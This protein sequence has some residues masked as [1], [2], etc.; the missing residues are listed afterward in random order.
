[1]IPAGDPR[2]SQDGSEK[3]AVYC[4]WHPA[5]RLGADLTQPA[6][7]TGMLL[8]TP[9]PGAPMPRGLHR[10][11]ARVAQAGPF[12]TA[13]TPGDGPLSRHFPP[14][15]WEMTPPGRLR[16]RQPSHRE[17]RARGHGPPERRPA[18]RRRARP[19]TR[20]PGP[21]A[22]QG[23]ARLADEVDP[24]APVELEALIAALTGRGR[25]IALLA[26]HLGLRP[27]EA[28]LAPWSA[29]DGKT[30]VVGRA[31]T[32][33]TAARTRVLAVPAPTAGELRAWRL[34][35]GGR[36]DEPIVGTMSENA[37]K[38][39]A[40]RALPDDVTLYR[41]RH[42]HASA[43]HYCGFTLPA[44]ARRMGHGGQLHLR[45][46]AHVIDTLGDTRYPDL[47]ALIETVRADLRLPVGCPTAEESR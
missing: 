13:S 15:L 32:K 16:A 1:V 4:E 17:H 11:H 43:L 39:W 21:V 30:L 46:Y 36:G 33:A 24:L 26:G 37:L 27:R 20:Q 5:Y 34:Q 14:G 8:A 41:L 35:S 38:L 40:R 25:A 44:A 12:L 19:P 9:P 29:F 6:G 28:R 18:G 10:P 47:V 22:A 3:P 7:G 42:T 2:A 23:P 31:R 45:T